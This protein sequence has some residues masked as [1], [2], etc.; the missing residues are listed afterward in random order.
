MFPLRQ[1]LSTDLV[2][3]C[4]ESLNPLIDVGQVEGAYVMGLGLFLTE[5]LAFDS[6]G[7]LLSVGT[8]E[9]KPMF[10][11]DIPQQ[12]TVTLIPD[13]PNPVGILSSKA[14]GEPSLALGASAHFAIKYAVRAARAD[15]GGAPGTKRCRYF[16]VPLFPSRGQSSFLW[17]FFLRW[18]QLTLSCQHLRRHAKSQLRA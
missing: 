9:Y 5:N 16:C 1:I 18:D 15:A 17:F 7:Q 8:F 13:A 6:T 10:P 14:T 3:D 2:Y 11:L 4:G 12:M